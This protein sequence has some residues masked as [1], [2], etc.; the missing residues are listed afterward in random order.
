MRSAKDEVMFLSFFLNKYFYLGLMYIL[1]LVILVLKLMFFTCQGNI[2]N[3]HVRFLDGFSTNIIF[4]FILNY[5][6]L[7]FSNFST[8]T[9]YFS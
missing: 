9:S 3:F 8:S 2:S 6:C 1:V 4:V 7:S 5:L